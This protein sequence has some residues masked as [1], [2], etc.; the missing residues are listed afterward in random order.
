VEDI[1]RHYLT[2]KASGANILHSLEETD[3]GTQ[4]YH[5]LY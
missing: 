5:V 1:E 3:F 4:E 2:A